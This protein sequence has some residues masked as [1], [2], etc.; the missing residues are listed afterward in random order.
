MPNQTAQGPVHPTPAQPP[1]AVPM[2][3]QT[4]PV[5]P[6]SL[7]PQIPMSY[8]GAGATP[9]TAPAPTQFATPFV[10]PGAWMQTPFPAAAAPPLFAAP[11]QPAPPAPVHH[12]AYRSTEMVDR[13][14]R[15][16]E[17]P[18]CKVQYSV[19]CVSLLT[20]D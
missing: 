6:T 8:F 20:H 3:A 2:M 7:P 5:L 18:K 11:A 17:Y 4:G 14:D 13:F 1:G 12:R 15:F 19:A 9:W 10:A 16:A